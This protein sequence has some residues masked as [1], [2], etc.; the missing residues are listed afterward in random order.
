MDK[1]NLQELEININDGAFENQANTAIMSP[2]PGVELT[3]L[4][5]NKTNRID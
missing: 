2:S 1:S 5:G 3:P 4:A